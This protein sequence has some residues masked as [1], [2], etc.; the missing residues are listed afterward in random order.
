MNDPRHRWEDPFDE[1]RK[2]SR[3]E[4]WHRLP[5]WAFWV[6]ISISLLAFVLLALALAACVPELR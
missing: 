6:L 1:L 3:L 2:P 5:V 4:N